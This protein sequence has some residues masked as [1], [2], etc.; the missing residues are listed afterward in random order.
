M[1][2]YR[3]EK[4]EIPI[5]SQVERVEALVKWYKPEKGYGFLSRED[6]FGDIMIHFSHLDKVGYTYIWPGDRIICD[7]ASGKTGPQVVRIIEVKVG[8]LESRSLSGARNPLEHS[9]FQESEGIIKWYNP[10]K[11]YGFIQPDDG[12]REIFLHA[13]VMRAAGCTALQPGLRVLAT[14]AESERGPIAQIIKV[15]YEEEKQT[16]SQGSSS[17]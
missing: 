15:I 8:S 5:E 10:D 12:G 11:G 7:V 9:T 1:I 4:N 2:I 17:L 14:F 6:G 3:Q 16:A 13:S